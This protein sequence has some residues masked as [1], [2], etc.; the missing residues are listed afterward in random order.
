[1]PDTLSLITYLLVFTVSACLLGYG[2]HQKNRIIQWASLM[3]P[4]LLASMR[5]GVGTDYGTYVSLFNQFSGLSLTDYL[6]TS[7]TAEPGFYL[8]IQLSNILIGDSRIMFTLAAIL[9]NVFFYLGLRRYGIRHPALVY[10]L[11]LTILFPMT[12]NVMRQGIAI[13]I[14]FYA[15]SFIL[16]RNF[17]KYLIWMIMASLFHISALLLIPLYLVNRLIKPER[18][19]AYP[20]FLIKLVGIATGIFILVPTTIMLVSQIPMFSKYGMYSVNGGEG[21]NL[22]IFLQLIVLSLGI[23]LARW[24]TSRK[25]GGLY[26]ML[27]FFATLEIIFATIGFSSTFIKRIGLYC[28]IFGFMLLTESTS[29]FKGVAGK[30]LTITITVF[31]GIAYFVI[32]YYLLGQANVIPYNFIG[33]A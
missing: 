22:T 13:S 30:S 32:A 33:G 3:P 11:Y 2:Y 9:S 18:N 24:S 10:F 20:T 17:K 1:M 23:V 14:A 29:I 7:S 15:F 21:A 26:M 4:I 5:Y 31:Y 12:L 27:L 19:N 25:N 6:Q 8:L 28:S 16:E